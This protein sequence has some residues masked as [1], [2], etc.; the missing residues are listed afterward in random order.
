MTDV[1]DDEAVLVY[2]LRCR[3]YPQPVDSVSRRRPCDGCG[4]KIWVNPGTVEAAAKRY[5]S[6][7]VLFLCRLCFDERNGEWAKGRLLPEQVEHLSDLSYKEIA[8]AAALVRVTRGDLSKAAAIQDEIAACPDG[9]RAKE[10]IEA[11]NR[12]L[13]TAHFAQ[14]SHNN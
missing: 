5:P 7:P 10:F 6:N 12:A 4:C 2:C 1:N 9:L 8:F 13:T 14:G 3:D 11:Y